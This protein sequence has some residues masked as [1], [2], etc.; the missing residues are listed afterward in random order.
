MVKRQI[1]KIDEDTCTGCGDCIPNC[2]EGALQIID[3]KAR[4]ISDLFCDGLGACIGHCP[5]DAISIEEREAEE[6]DERKVMANVVK[7]GPNVIKAHLVHLKEHGQTDYL[8]TAIDYLKENNMEVPQLGEVTKEEPKVIATTSHGAVHACP[9][10]AV[11]DFRE[12]KKEATLPCGCPGSTVIDLKAEEELC[13]EDVAQVTPKGGSKSELGQWP[14]QIMLVPPNAPY[15]K[16]ADILIAADCV[17]FAYPDFHKDFLKNKILLVGC[18]KLDDTDFY[19][20]KLTQL[21]LMNDIK[22]ITIVHME[23]PCCFGLVKLVNTAVGNSGKNI[24]ISGYI[25]GVKGDVKE[26]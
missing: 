7:E 5:V 17:P 13:V 10:S 25:I 16:N 15:L 21:F 1:I 8:N 24:P 6:Y 3:D 2:P 26:T 14:V 9:G 4:I 22:S 20:Q 12:E 23:V 19:L 18:P 11:M